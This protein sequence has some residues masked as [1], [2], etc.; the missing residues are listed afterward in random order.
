MSKF[1]LASALFVAFVVSV[2]ADEPPKPDNKPMTSAT[3]LITGLHCPPCTKVVEGSLSKAA[4][5]HSVKVDWET[6]N[7][8][9]EFDETVIPAERVAQLIAATPHMMGPNLHYDGWLAL[10]AAGVK[11]EASAKTAKDAISKVTGVKK[12][13][14]FPAQHMVEVQFAADG[15]VTS[16]QLID[17]LASAGIKAENY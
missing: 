13:E 1:F 3:Y 5:V 17:A 2:R 8:K 14:A 6:K 10:K 11:D 9:I 15:N 12:V 7:A 4:G 16:G